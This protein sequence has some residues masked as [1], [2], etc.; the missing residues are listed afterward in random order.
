MVT[1]TRSIKRV[2]KI[3][4]EYDYD[5]DE[6]KDLILKASGLEGGEVIFDISSDGYLME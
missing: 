6:I 3:V 1:R 4:V 5:D 2:E